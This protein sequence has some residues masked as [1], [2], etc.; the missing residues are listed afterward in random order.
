M[1]PAALE[2]LYATGHWLL[3][4]GRPTDASRVFRLMTLTKPDDERGWLAL[5]SC[6][7]ALEQQPIALEMYRI[8]MIA[9]A[10]AV[11]CAVA[12]ARAFRALDADTEATEA[13]ELAAELAA[14]AGEME[15]A[16]LAEREMAI[17]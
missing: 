5:G 9:A 11:R 17:R 6:H 1:T 14:A 10:P 7:E 8:G 3:T 4:T 16:R 2:I 12:R 15:L 13:F